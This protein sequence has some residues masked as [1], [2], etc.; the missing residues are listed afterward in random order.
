V[1]GK[2]VELAFQRA[3]QER[4]SVFEL[5]DDQ[6]PCVS[7]HPVSLRISGRRCELVNFTIDQK[8]LIRQVRQN[9]A[10]LQQAAVLLPSEKLAESMEFASERDCYLFAFTLARVTRRAAELH[11]A[12]SLRMPAYLVAPLP[13]R[14]A[15]PAGLNSL[16]HL[17]A[18]VEDTAA[19]V[20][21]SP[22]SLELGGR[23]CDGNYQQAVLEFNAAGRQEVGVEF[24]SLAYLHTSR[25]PAVR[26][27]IYS[28]RLD[29][30]WVVSPSQWGN[31]WVY[32]LEIILVGWISRGAFHRL[33]QRIPPGSWVPFHPGGQDKSLSVRVEQLRS[34][35]E[36]FPGSA[37]HISNNHL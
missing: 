2:A 19:N 17:A 24:Q 1:A 18:K 32:G 14:W 15:R 11:Q 16:G 25:L 13:L 22:L 5:L 35:D 31:L 29:Q 10:C 33:A 26:V 27:G 12:L 30:V 20:M 4:Q 36:L 34:F 37:Y 21:W 28:S 23:G 9:P 6:S 3:L 7:S 8:H